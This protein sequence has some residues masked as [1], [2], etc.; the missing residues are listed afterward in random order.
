MLDEVAE[1]LLSERDVR[2]VVVVI[3]AKDELYR[4]EFEL[5]LQLELKVEGVERVFPFAAQHLMPFAYALAVAR[6]Q[7]LDETAHGP[8][9]AFVLV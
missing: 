1:S 4:L 3:P 7:I 9:N 8:V 6:S 5:F 2:V